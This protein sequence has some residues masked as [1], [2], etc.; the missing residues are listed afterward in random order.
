MSRRLV[1]ICCSVLIVVSPSLARAE[2]REE[3]RNYVGGISSLAPPAG[4][5]T[6]V[7]GSVSANGVSFSLL[8]GENTVAM[9]ILD[10]SLPLVGARYEFTR[11]I[12]ELGGTIRIVDSVGSGSLCG[13][14]SIAVPSDATALV[15][16]LDGSIPGADVTVGDQPVVETVD[17]PCSEL[18]PGTTGRIVAVFG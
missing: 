14:T 17:G 12:E 8:G 7:T 4:T 5:S 10:D 2:A 13:S 11:V 1:L 3:T 16:R 6:D 18:S 15:I 9:E